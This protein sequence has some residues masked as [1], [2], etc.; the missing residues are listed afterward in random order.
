MKIPL[1]EYLRFIIK[2]I[3]SMSYDPLFKT[4]LN[5]VNEKLHNFKNDINFILCLTNF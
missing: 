5:V 4:V 3:I 1:L 2:K